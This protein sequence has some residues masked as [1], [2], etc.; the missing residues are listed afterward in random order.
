[1]NVE[2]H[3]EATDE[4]RDAIV[5]HE[6]ERTGLGRELWDE[7]L[8]AV[9][10]IELNPDGPERV[11]PNLHRSPIRRFQYSLIYGVRAN[12]LWIVAVAHHSRKEGYWRSRVP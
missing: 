11:R 6:T 4:V 1:M 10:R 9:Q 2:F 8:A 5:F 12:T 7:I 3:P